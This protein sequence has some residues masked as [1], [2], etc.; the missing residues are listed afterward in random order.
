MDRHNFNVGDV[1]R[2]C[3]HF[4]TPNGQIIPFETYNLLYRDGAVE[5]F[6]QSV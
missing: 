4:V 1:K 3:I 6:R 5:K 2:S